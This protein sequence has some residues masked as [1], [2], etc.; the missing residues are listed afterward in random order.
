[1]ASAWWAARAAAMLG[2]CMSSGGRPGPVRRVFETWE[3]VRFWPAGPSGRP[4]AWENGVG[5][6]PAAV[7][8]PTAWSGGTDRA[9]EGELPDPGRVPPQAASAE[10]SS[11]AP[12]RPG[13]QR[14]FTP[15]VEPLTTP[16]LRTTAAGNENLVGSRLGCRWPGALQS[17]SAP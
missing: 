5:G 12:S 7:F 2:Y 10:V 15:P 1:M 6:A 11:N 9:G 16:I 13:R 17:A 4:G 3:A 8:P 14:Q